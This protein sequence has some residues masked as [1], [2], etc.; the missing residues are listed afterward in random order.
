MFES[1]RTGSHNKPYQGMQQYGLSC[2]FKPHYARITYTSPISRDV[3]SE[4]KWRCPMLEALHKIGK[5]L[6]T[7]FEEIFNG[8]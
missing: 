3:L 8:F 2:D 1:C 5:A 4:I 6:N 7:T